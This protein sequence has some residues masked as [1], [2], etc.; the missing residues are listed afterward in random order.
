MKV[1]SL[2][3]VNYKEGYV[4]IEKHWASVLSKSTVVGV[5]LEE[6]AKAG[7]VTSEVSNVLVGPMHYIFKHERADVA[8]VCAAEQE[9]PPLLAL[10]FLTRVADIFED[11]FGGEATEAAFRDNFVTTYQLLEEMMDAGMPNTTEGN[12]LKE[13]VAPPNVITKLASKLSG[14]LGVSAKE[15][16]PG[17]AQSSIP[18]RRSGVKYAS[19]EIFF[20]ISESIDAILDAEGHLISG[21]VYGDILASSKL[22]GVPDL[23]L[24]FENPAIMEDIAFHPCIR[25]NRW[26]ADR[27]L[28]FVPPDGDFKL[29]SYRVR[30][31]ALMHN[32]MAML[33][34]YIKP[35]LTVTQQ[36][37]RL[38]VMVGPRVNLGKPLEDVVIIIPLPRHISTVDLTANHGTISFDET[39]KICTWDIGRMPKDKSPILQGNMLLRKDLGSKELSDVDTFILDQS[40]TIQANFKVVG[41]NLSGLRVDALKLHGERYVP[42][43]G[44]RFSTKSGFYAVRT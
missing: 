29:L 31:S 44:V 11:Y 7:G 26:G 22:S 37:G 17:G 25:Y 9:M 15:A 18:W 10:E 43:K 12:I 20:D 34:M 40:V 32:G 30:D 39:T 19:N 28:S 21:S 41:A 24:T 38:S 3:V 23:T 8:Y 4:I 42:S 2:F 14:K 35:Q 36:S 33:P 1:Q 27:V 5:Y 16:L 6:L 13:M